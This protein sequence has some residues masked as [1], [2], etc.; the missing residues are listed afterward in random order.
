MARILA[1]D[2]RAINREFLATLLGYAGHEV[3][4]AADGAQALELVRRERPDLVI[5]DVL[6]PVM[7][8]VQFADRV[9]EDPSIAHTPILFYT[10]TYRLPEAKV[11]ADTCRVLGVLAKPAEPQEML[12][13]VNAALGQEVPHLDLPAPA[14][15]LAERGAK[16]PQY[17]RELARRGK[18]GHDHEGGVPATDA[19]HA[20]NLR[21]ST[22]LEFDLALASERSAQGMVELFCSASQDIVGAR[23]AAVGILDNEGR[24][25]QFRAC[26]G[27]DAG[28]AAA[29][30]QMGLPD[31]LFATVIATDRPQVL[32]DAAGLAP[33]L[34]LGGLHA[35]VTSMLVVPVPVR[36]ATS[37]HG[38]LYLAGRLGA[39]RFLGED[40]QF[41]ITLAMQFALTFGNLVLYD[42]IQHHAAKLEVEVRERRRTE[43]DL[44][45]RIDHDQT[46]GLPR[47]GPVEAALPA[48][49]AEARARGR[50]VL[51]LYV[52]I[53]RFHS[54]N[55]TR[56]R[57]A[58][59]NVLRVIGNRL[60]SQ[61]APD[62]LLAHIAADEFA[63]VVP[64]ARQ[65]PSALDV[66]E[67]LRR[68]IEKPIALAGQRLYVTAS[69]GVSAFPEQGDSPQALLR[70]AEAAMLRAKR[71][72]RNGVAVFSN[73]QRQEL[74]ERRA[75]GLR[76][77][78]ALRAGQFT[79]H[80]QPQVNAADGQI[81]GF[82]ALVRWQ[83][84]EL[85]L[86]PP[87]R[88]LGIAEE[89]GLTV[90]IG[91]FVLE[92]ACRQIRSWIDAGA[93]DFSVAV[94]VS[95]LQLQRPDFVDGVRAMLLGWRCRRGTWRSSSPRT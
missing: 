53:D 45:H 49:F 61:I 33:E 92:S 71:E 9:H 11:L 39:E 68:C 50:R 38:W 21:L 47:F 86:L 5:T 37:V 26:R 85:G 67:S 72:G 35:P 87:A 94:N 10:A 48:L 84:P 23:Y 31:G 78:D 95:S 74:D 20:L 30:A 58:G 44:A 80:Y 91:S 89:L 36:S 2:D 93:E 12:R 8:G 25:L 51:V 63:C 40:E 18:H 4:Q 60:S 22:L 24:A 54:I 16:L 32:H 46:T 70:H 27:F 76:L 57:E 6:M 83:D 79:L 75:L 73:E 82:E 69:V 56:G 59:D 41:A 13:A 62:G 43:A 64:A 19:F 55:E 14:P 29:F 66:A 65:T 15:R 77:P 7:D 34:G 1:V 17:L 88:F 81:A 42:E 90:D 52:D 3:L 28:G